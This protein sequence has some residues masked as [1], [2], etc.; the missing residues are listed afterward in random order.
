M[1]FTSSSGAE[2][3]TPWPWHR[4][5]GLIAGGG[6]ISLL[7]D[8]VAVLALVLAASARPHGGAMVAALLTAALLPAIVLA[9]VSGWL[10]DRLSAR[11]IVV[12]TSLAQAAVCLA[13]AQ[14][15]GQVGTGGSATVL[16]LVVALNAGATLVQPAWQALVPAV[17]PESSVGTALAWVQTGRALGG[18]AGPAVGGLLVGLSGARAALLVD[19]ATFVALAAA[20]ALLDRDRRPHRSD[21]VA[22]ESGWWREALAGFTTITHDP[23]LRPM[24][25]L[26]LAFVLTLGLV[27]VVEV[28][29]ITTT[30]GA[31]PIAYGVIGA[32]FAA[33]TALGAWRS[34]STDDDRGLARQ[35]V[36]ATCVIAAGIG[37]VG[38]SP[39][40]VW[41]ALA[42]AAIGVGNG[43]L[44]VV[45]QHLL[46][47]RTPSDRLG[48][49]MA[50]V[51]GAVNAAM[52]GSLALGGLLAS[53]ASPRSL[54]LATSVAGL[55]AI[56]LTARPLLRVPPAPLPHPTVDLGH[57]VSEEAADARAQ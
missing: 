2:P 45:A 49:V 47:R 44:N 27:N 25:I 41:A 54:F 50:A 48:R 16:A 21:D 35:F 31:S 3:P 24:M 15:S 12:V 29:F 26:T 10:V 11:R 20:A 23:V 4:N 38:L 52:I 7:G 34:R 46:I 13:L 6:A 1:S 56:A 18:L 30:L 8:E 22:T 39:G 32:L 53:L 51:Q 36:V 17:V 33:G 14:V 5:A 43:A 55:V 57:D 40:I 42:S 37:L 28:F 9:P 19:A